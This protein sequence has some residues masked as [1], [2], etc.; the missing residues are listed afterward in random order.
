[1]QRMLV[2]FTAVALVA[3]PAL[4]ARAGVR[5][6]RQ[7]QATF[8]LPERNGVTPFIY[9]HVVELRGIG[10]REFFSMGRGVCSPHTTPKCVTDRKSKIGRRLRQ[11]DVLDIDPTLESAHL[12]VR[13]RGKTHEVIWTGLG[14]LAPLQDDYECAGIPAGEVGVGRTA[15]AKGRVFG[16]RLAVSSDGGGKAGLKA[17]AYGC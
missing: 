13:V 3:A 1:M 4:P 9:V 5:T 16:H 11:G 14:R 7:A 15:G 6:L 10:I 12:K 17:A 2:V 8:L